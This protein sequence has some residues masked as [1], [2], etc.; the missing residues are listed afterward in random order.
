[1]GISVHAARGGPPSE[2]QLSR[3]LW[4]VYGLLLDATRAAMMMMPSATPA[5]RPR[6]NC[7]M[8]PESPSPSPN[9][10]SRQALDVG[11]H[12]VCELQADVEF[13]GGAS[14]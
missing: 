8:A 4:D 5:S 3:L 6:M 9:E 10:H 7:H 13:C 2:R 1:M 12:H 11:R 14:L